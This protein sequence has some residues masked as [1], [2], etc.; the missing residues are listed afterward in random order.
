MD[1]LCDTMPPVVIQEE[2]VLRTLWSSLFKISIFSLDAW[3]I[4]SATEDNAIS[5]RKL[6]MA[7]VLLPVL[8]V[9][10]SGYGLS[11]IE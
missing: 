9:H 10:R 7:I 8:G 4:A 5:R 2:P 11:V 6:V 1:P 3:P